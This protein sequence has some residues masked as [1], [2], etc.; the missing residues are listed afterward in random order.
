[1]KTLCTRIFVMAPAFLMIVGTA[2]IRRVPMEVPVDL[3]STSP[4]ILRLV[5]SPRIIHRGETAVITWNVRNVSRILLEEALE[6]D[7]TAANRFL[8]P[9]GDFPANG[10]LAVSPKTTATYVLSCGAKNDAGSACT[11][12]SVTVIVK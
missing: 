11:S 12:A 9:L 4:Q 6:P 3:S 1:M 7:G 8:H 10:R 2:C 5:V